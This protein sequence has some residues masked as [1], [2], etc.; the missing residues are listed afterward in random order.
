MHC[1]TTSPDAPSSGSTEEIVGEIQ[2]IHWIYRAAKCLGLCF[3]TFSW[4][5]TNYRCSF[6]HKNWVF[7]HS[8]IDLYGTG[9]VFSPKYLG[10][11]SSVH[12]AQFVFAVE[13]LLLVNPLFLC[14][15]VVERP[16]HPWTRTRNT[17]SCSRLS[18]THK[19]QL[20]KSFGQIFCPCLFS[21]ICMQFSLLSDLT[22]TSPQ[23]L[24]FIMTLTIVG[25]IRSIV[26]NLQN[27]QQKH[28]C[29]GHKTNQ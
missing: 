20:K 10:T 18:H 22:V 27:I 29:T 13:F 4:L 26:F 17:L 1:P 7:Y 12:L 16:P 9:L 15:L 23:G 6:K 2:H 19:I 5:F 8:S 11:L 28:T 14:G 24:A 25:G 21:P 3:C